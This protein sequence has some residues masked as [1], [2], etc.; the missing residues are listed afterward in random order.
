[1]FRLRLREE[2]LLCSLYSIHDGP[3]KPVE[4]YGGGIEDQQSDGQA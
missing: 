1:M 4:E 3:G 2:Q